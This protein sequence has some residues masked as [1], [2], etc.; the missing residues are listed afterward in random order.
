MTVSILFI[1]TMG[2]QSS[3]LRGNINLFTVLKGHLPSSLNVEMNYKEMKQKEK[4]QSDAI[5]VVCARNDSVW[6][7][8]M[9]AKME[10]CKHIQDIL[11]K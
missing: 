3:I 7:E 6:A 4:H 11:W 10:K 9:E 8:I 1:T 5:I 2:S